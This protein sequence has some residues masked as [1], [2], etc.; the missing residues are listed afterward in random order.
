MVG[1]NRLNAMKVFAMTAEDALRD[2]DRMVFPGMREISLTNATI[3]YKLPARVELDVH[4]LP[5]NPFAHSKRNAAG[6]TKITGR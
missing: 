6:D 2:T 3:R 5:D 1:S 4:P